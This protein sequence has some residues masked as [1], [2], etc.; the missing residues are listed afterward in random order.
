MNFK[1]NIISFS[2]GISGAGTI[3]DFYK[4]LYLVLGIN[5]KNDIFFASNI[6]NNSNS[7]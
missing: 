6:I 2:K 5:S 3:N 4:L 1:N 7:H